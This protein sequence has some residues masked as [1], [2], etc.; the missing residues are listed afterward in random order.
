LTLELSFLLISGLLLIGIV[1]SKVSSRLG[2]P[3]LLLFLAI[4]MLAGSEGPGGIPFDSA[5]VAQ[6]VGVIALSYILFAGGFDTNWKDVR[7]AFRYGIVLSTLGVVLTA[8]VLAVFAQYALGFGWI[9]A[10]LLGSIV[11]STDAAAVFAVLRS[12]N[13]NL[14]GVVAPVLELESGSNDPMA[15]F[16]T[17]GC[18]R[19]A[20][21]PGFTIAN[22]I[23]AFFLEMSVGGLVGYGAGQ[24][25][26]SALNR[27]KLHAEGLYPVF[28]LSLVLLTYGAASILQGNGFLAVYLAGIVLGRER[29]IHKRSLLNFHD[30][31]A[32]LMQ[33]TMFLTLG[34]LVFPSEIISVTGVGLFL[35]FILMFVARPASVFVSLA[36]TNLSLREKTFISWVGLKGAVPIILATFPLLAD[37]PNSL[38]YFNVVFFIVIASVLLQGTS[39]PVVAR[40]LRLDEPYAGKRQ[41]PLEFFPTSKSR[42]EMIEVEVADNSRM[43]GRRILDIPLPTTALIVLISRGEEYVIPRGATQIEPGDRL[44]V[45]AERDIIQQVRRTFYLE[46]PGEAS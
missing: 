46:N 11:S 20:T 39:L 36:F 17:L 1:A 45:L 33:I 13:A 9:Q 4:G 24:L 5:D 42:S 6:T 21:E 28:T 12:R 31:I 25:G 26:V 38:L 30:G 23:P 32:W 15:V 18:I 16:L 7:L 40:W 22:L 34:L 37:V 2:I 8:V 3:S 27:I 10:L 14:K 41:S 43:V 29:F 19:M 35:A 44:L